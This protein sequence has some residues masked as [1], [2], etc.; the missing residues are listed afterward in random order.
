MV[1]N[2]YSQVII[3]NVPCCYHIGIMHISE[4]PIY[5]YMPLE[6]L[7]G[8][9]RSGENV[10]VS[11]LKWDDP[12]EAA[13][14]K[15]PSKWHDGSPVDVSVLGTELFAQCWCAD[16]K[17]S[18]L[19]WKVYG[20]GSEVVR[21]GT[22]IGK[23]LESINAAFPDK[24][25]MPIATMFGE[26]K[27]ISQCDLEKIYSEMPLIR[28]PELVSFCMLLK[29]DAY[30]QEEEWRILIRNVEANGMDEFRKNVKI[31]GSLMKIPIVNQEEF[32][33]EIIV[34]SHVS[35]EREQLLRQ[36]I[37]KHG[38]KASIVKSRILELPHFSTKY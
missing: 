37:L 35:H 14:V 9:I 31:E 17:E 18:D 30:R 32:I 33:T 24:T 19:R 28:H 23:L 29:R 1:E 38:W 11:P 27:Y 3:C 7:L 5:R 8:M 6:Y 16:K 21:I 10:L 15:V 34:G 2:A 25:A 4:M 26:V 22:T 12:F 13:V 20:D 36:E